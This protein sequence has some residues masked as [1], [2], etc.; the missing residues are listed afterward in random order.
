M[1]DSAVRD[2]F[3]VQRMTH[4]QVMQVAIQ[5]VAADTIN[6]HGPGWITGIEV[7]NLHLHLNFK[8]KAAA[9]GGASIW[10]S[11]LDSTYST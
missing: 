7:S 3:L 4:W 2:C 9:A 10:V 6:S 1:S 11:K 8:F 5:V